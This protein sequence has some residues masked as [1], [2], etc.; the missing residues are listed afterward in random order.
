MPPR[1][2]F[3]AL[4][5]AARVADVPI[6]FPSVRETLTLTELAESSAGMAGGLASRGVAPG[7]PV[8]LLCPNA[9]EFLRSFFAVMRLGAVVCPLPIAAGL[10]QI[11]TYLDRLQRIAATAGMKRIVMSHRFAQLAGI[12]SEH[13]PGVD[14]I[15]TDTVHA[16]GPVAAAHV[17]G[18]DAAIVQF[19]S[20]STADPKGV[21]LTHDNAL[22]GLD[23][24]TVG[25]EISRAD[26]GGFW[27]PLFHD[28]GLFATL[29]SILNARPVTIWSPTEFIKRPTDWLRDFV[30]T[31]ATVSAFPNFGYDYLAAAC[32]AEDVKSVGSMS[33]WRITFN[34][35]ESITAASTEGFLRRFAPA[36]FRPETMFC[37]Y[38]M[39][40]ATLAVTFPPLGRAPLFDA[41][42]RAA[43]SDGAVV[44]C[45]RD[46]TRA[47]LVANVGTPV[48]GMQLRLVDPNGQTPTAPD[49]VGEVQ[50]RGSAVTPGYIGGQASTFTTDGWLPTGDLGYL[51][52]GD[53]HVTGRAKEM[54][55]VRGMNFYP[56]DVENLVRTNPGIYRGRCVAF[57]DP[58][59]ETMS[60]IAETAVENPADRTKLLGELHEQIRGSL[61]FGEVD[62]TLLEPRSIPTTT[63]GKLQ[64]LAARRLLVSGRTR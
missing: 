56:E 28:M 12:V 33:H 51:R 17:H 22:A 36:G 9:P 19:T 58:E 13:L 20:G 1:T 63:S 61:Q 50:L 59:R 27:L 54:I 3:A 47:R 52:G 55:T 30:A 42:D 18:E 32:S 23:A 38:G 16:D 40:E 14:V 10:T 62:I 35:A 26:S 2:V 41:V 6:S 15:V 31:G 7:E 5:E 45:G 43:L 46:D 29:A 60:L 49:R 8:G 48:R 39:A 37:V 64:R 24:I 44:P 11:D 25:I 34:G 21:V 4:D 53:L 57:T